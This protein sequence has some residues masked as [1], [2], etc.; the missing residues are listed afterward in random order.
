MKL[1]GGY[2]GLDNTEMEKQNDEVK[3]IDTN[4]ITRYSQINEDLENRYKTA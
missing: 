3:R 1:M 4:A 2:K